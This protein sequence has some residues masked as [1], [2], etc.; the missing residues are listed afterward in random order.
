MKKILWKFLG[1]TGL[2]SAF[3][4]WQNNGLQVTRINY[5]SDMLPAAFHGYQ[6]L[7]ISDLQS[8]TFGKNQRRLVQ[9]AENAA[10]DAIFITG[11]LVDAN[12]T[13]MEAAMELVKQL[14]YI[15]PVYYVSGNHEYRSGIYEDLMLFLEMEGVHVLENAVVQL[16]RGGDSVD[17]LGL[18]DIRANKNYSFVLKKLVKNTTTN[19]RILLSHRPELFDLYSRMG[20]QLT[21]A[22]HAHGGQIRLPFIG[23]LFAP[24]QGFLP[25]WTSGLYRLGGSDLI[26]SR[27]LGNSKF[28]FRIYNRPEV[29]VVRLN[30]G[31]PPCSER[32][33]M[34]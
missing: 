24:N 8:K 21:F 2:L 29:V 25:K 14:V 28:P 12:R 9:A 20:I 27:G 22:G 16:E 7:H 32:S 33:K 15:A 6:I 26:V 1:A 11:D 5:Y 19:F 17:L 34:V 23:G 4:Y 13:D 3:L 30:T 31:K 18:A 10:A